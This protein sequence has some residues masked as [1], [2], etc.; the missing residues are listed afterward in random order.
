M[1]KLLKKCLRRLLP[2]SVNSGGY[3]ENENENTI[4]TESSVRIEE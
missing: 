2:F 1:G 3:L 4:V